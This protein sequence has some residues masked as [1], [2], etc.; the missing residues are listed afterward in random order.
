MNFIP[1]KVSTLYV[2][3]IISILHLLCILN[4]AKKLILIGIFEVVDNTI[5]HYFFDFAPF[6]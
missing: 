6:R 3:T 5:I 4:F 2:P 1:V